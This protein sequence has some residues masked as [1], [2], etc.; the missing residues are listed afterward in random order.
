MSTLDWIVSVFLAA[1]PVLAFWAGAEL[2][3]RHDRHLRR[4]LERRFA[5]HLRPL[6]SA[7]ARDRREASR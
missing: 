3:H 5:N 6:P 2:A 4:D 7:P 1:G